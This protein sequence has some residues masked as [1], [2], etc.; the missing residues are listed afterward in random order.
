M[1]PFNFSIESTA[2]SPPKPT[3][4][5]IPLEVVDLL[6]QLVDAQREQL[7]CLKAIAAAH[8]SMARWRAF[9]SRWQDQ[10]P[11]LSPSCRKV[12]PI[13]EQTYGR[14]ITDLTEHLAANGDDPLDNDFSLQEF[15]DRYGMRL[16]QLGTILNL[17]APLAEAG[18]PPQQQ[19]QGGQSGGGGTAG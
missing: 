14:L 11:E 17:V 2:P 1:Q 8:D 18:P 4:G 19:Q 9:V 6:R 7:Q 13:L 12:L 5:S 16:G 3:P 15:L 10:F